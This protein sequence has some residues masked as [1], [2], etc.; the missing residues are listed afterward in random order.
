MVPLELMAAASATDSAIQSKIY[1]SGIKTLIFPNEEFDNI[2]K[3]VGKPK[4]PGRWVIRTGE[5]TIRAG[6]TTTRTGQ[7]F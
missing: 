7:H 4:I 1:G 6:E 3:I 2:I 5:G